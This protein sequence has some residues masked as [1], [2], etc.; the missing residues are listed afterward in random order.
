MHET[1]VTE[2]NIQNP[3]KRAMGVT[4]KSI[5]ITKLKHISRLKFEIPDPDVYLL[6]G[7]NGAGKTSLLACLHRIGF[8]QAFARHFRSS[9]Q[10][11]ILDNY[12]GSEVTYTL[13]TASVTYAYAGERWVPRPRKNSGLLGKFGFP[14]VVYIGATADR[15]TPRPED[16][17]PTRLGTASQ[18]IRDTANR[19]F[20]TSKFDGLKV[21]NLTPGAGNQAFLL[22]A[23]PPP[24]ATYFSERNFSLGELCVLKL[25]R[26]LKDCK[27]GALVLIDELELALHPKAQ[28]ELLQYLQ[29]FAPTKNLTVIFSTHSVS[30]LKSVRRSDILFLDNS[31]NAT[32]TV[33]GCYPAFAIGNMA[34]GEERAPD[35]VIYV[36]DDAAAYV[37]EALLQLHLNQ[38]HGE[39]VAVRPTVQV[40][41]IGPFMSVVRH[42]GGSDALLS[43]TTRTS[44]LLDDDVQAETVANWT[45]TDNHAR[46]AEFQAQVGRIQYLPWTPEVG[47]VRYLQQPGRLAEQELRQ[48]FG[49]NLLAVRPADIGVIPA[50][51]GGNQRRVCK[52]AVT[53]VVQHLRTFLPTLSESEI[54]RRVFAVFATW[55]FLHHRPSVMT[56]FGALVP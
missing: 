17:T 43:P 23:T 4:V 21:V 44:A 38:K 54:E 16:F 3:T 52:T 11:T 45:A 33:R 9:T 19:I 12:G 28:I 24:G 29:A 48:H 1:L 40:L 41:P 51:P 32:I 10:S 25:L 26:R 46:L 35:A 18:E 8:S 5:E 56:L 50:I 22:Q 37:T 47:L 49:N 6:S 55:H 2:I 34:Y 13:A 15:I 20:A 7:L 53:N 30:L 27:K 42:L 39:T 14:E 36:E 31:A